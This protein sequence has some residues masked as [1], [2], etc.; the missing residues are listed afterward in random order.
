MR[1]VGLLIVKN[2]QGVLQRCLDSWSKVCDQFFILDTGSS[3]RDYLY[4]LRSSKPFNYYCTSYDNFHFDVA[5]NDCIAYA[6]REGGVSEGTYFCMIDA[7][8][9]LP[10]DFKFPEL[11]EDV[12]AINYRTSMFTTHVHYRIWRSDLRLRYKGAVHEHLVLSN[13]TSAILPLE[14]VHSPLPSKDKD[15][16]RNLKILMANRNTTRELFYLGNE[17]MDLGRFD[18]ACIYWQHYINRAKFEPV[19]WEELQCCYWRLARYTQDKDECLKIC[20]EGLKKFPA[21]GE[22]QAEVSYRYGAKYAPKI[23]W[24]EHLFGERQYYC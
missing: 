18:E 12:Y 1:V 3:N 7:D 10:P 2:E 5:R 15:P 16:Q 19:W 17:L 4:D 14:V 11:T 6:E 23:P 8:D 9:I 21:C 22:L 20:E 13:N 24:Y